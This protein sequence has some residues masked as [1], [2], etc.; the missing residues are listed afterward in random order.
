MRRGLNVTL[1]AVLVGVFVI[2]FLAGGVLAQEGSYGGTLRVAMEAEC[3]ALDLALITANLA[4][5]VGLHIYETLFAYDEDFQ[6]VPFLAESLEYNEDRT[7]ATIRLRHGVLFHN[8]EEMD[9][10]DVAASLRRSFQYGKRGKMIGGYVTDVAAP[11]KYTV[12]VTFSSS[13]G[14]L[15]N[16]LAHFPGGLPIIPAEIA[17][18]AGGNKLGPDQY[19]GTGPYKFMEHIPGRHIKLVRF[20][21]YQPLDQ[22]PSGYAGRRIAYFDE[23]LFMPVPEGATRLAGVQVGDYDYGLSMDSKVY[24][25]AVAD[26]GILVRRASPPSWSFVAFAHKSGPLSDPLLREA[27]MI[28]LDFDEIVALAHGSLGELSPSV[29]HA[30]TP[31]YT[32][33]G[34]EWYNQ[35]D[36][37][38]AKELMEQAGYDGE[39]IVFLST[40]RTD[41]MY[42]ESLVIT[43]QLTNI[44]FNVELQLFDWATVVSRRYDQGLWDLLIAGHGGY[45]EPA[46]E[47]FLNPKKQFY[48]DS[49]GIIELTKQLIGETEYKTRFAIWEDIQTLLYNEAILFKIADTYT[50]DI[51]SV[52]L[53]GLAE[54][55]IVKWAYFWNLWFK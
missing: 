42:Y 6:P 47:T 26:P 1:Q 50:W 41:G 11:D 28:A 48:W 13:F 31:W 37:E 19:I 17:E 38:R 12:V 51:G 34:T 33:T 2:C 32:L 9:S 54:T 52:H 27:I 29:M 7:I 40:T 10:K 16:L 35:K 15:T 30:S 23:I 8:G 36:T 46:V 49:P 43:R 4:S 53:G 44:G 3:P 21:D 14:P 24:D 18:A 20:E 5:V 22:D 45:S 55:E 39:P 25:L